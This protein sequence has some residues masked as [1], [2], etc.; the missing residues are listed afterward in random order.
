[1]APER[2]TLSP[3]AMMA[4]REVRE[5]LEPSVCGVPGVA[6]RCFSR[7]LHPPRPV[8]VAQEDS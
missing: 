2:A 7:S 5:L 6:G 3:T 1:M 4:G 8:G